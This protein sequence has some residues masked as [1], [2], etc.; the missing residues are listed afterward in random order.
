MLTFENRQIDQAKVDLNRWEPSHI[1]SKISIAGISPYE[2][3]FFNREEMTNA[4]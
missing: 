1:E 3:S 4:I 2:A